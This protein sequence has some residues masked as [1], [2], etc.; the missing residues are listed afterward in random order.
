MLIGDALNELARHLEAI[1]AYRLARVVFEDLEAWGPVA[2]CD[3]G[4]GNA[5]RLLGNN[6]QA[7]DASRLGPKA[8]RP[9]RRAPPA[10][11]VRLRD[12]NRPP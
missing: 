9:S 1:E 12:R 2:A 8:L 4:T 7:V 11:G 10:C 3:F 5:L 6:L